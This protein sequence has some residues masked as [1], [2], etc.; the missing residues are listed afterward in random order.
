MTSG[1]QRYVE[2]LTRN[3]NNSI[4]TT[5]QRQDSITRD[6]SRENH[7]SRDK[8]ATPLRRDS[9]NGPAK[10]RPAHSHTN[11]RSTHTLPGRAT[12]RSKERGSRDSSSLPK[13][14]GGNSAKSPSA[15]RPV[16]RDK[17]NKQNP[18]DVNKNSKKNIPR[19]SSL[20][21]G[22]ESKVNKDLSRVGSL[23]EGTTNE[24]NRPSKR[25]P[26]S[27]FLLTQHQEKVR[28]CQMIRN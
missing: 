26:R 23:R 14:E 9:L 17:S 25:R 19:K 28:P 11:R 3:S 24:I 20:C 5:M 1:N 15:G 10:D 18:A 13:K 4:D 8:R 2:D 6:Y 27:A 16:P 21:E 22:E 12:E 7:V